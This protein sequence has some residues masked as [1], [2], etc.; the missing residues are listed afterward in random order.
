[1]SDKNKQPT[2]YVHDY[3]TFGQRP[4]L[5]RPAQFAGVRTDLDFNLVEEP[6][7]IYCKPADDYLPQPEAVMIT[8]I[9]PQ[10]ALANGVNEAEFS[11]QIHQAFSVP[12]TC[13]LGYNNIRFDDE[14]S[15]NIFYRNFYDPYAYSWQGGNSRWDLLDVMRA[16]YALRPEG[17]VWPENDDGLPSFK[18]EH[19]TKANGVEH[20]QAHDAMSDVY[21]TIAMAKLVKQAQPRLFDYLYQHRSKHKI[22]ALIDIAEMTPLVHVS[23]MFGAARGNTSWVAPLAWHPENKN[24]VIMCD[25]AGDMSPL[26]ELDSDTLRE[27][28]YTRRDKLQAQESAI[29]IK[30][31]HINKCPV[32]APAKTLLPENADRLGID[33]QRCLQNLQLLRQNP[34]VREKVV[35]LFAQAEPFA[36]TDDVD[37]Q[38]YNGFFSDA[39]RAT[40]KIIQQTEPQNLPALDLTFQDPRLEA[41]L[42]RFR[43]RNYPNTLNNSEQQRWLQHRRE[44]LSPERVQDYVLQLEQFYNQYEDDKEKL[45]LLKALFEY[46]KGLVS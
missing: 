6:L 36:V 23:G 12:G 5:D 1:M 39:D 33:R 25:L 2:F 11:R 43:A 4:A 22:N 42:F 21:A 24:A 17:I 40:M 38:L 32:L 18:L 13:I 19:L 15:R 3:E 7:V 14:V 10:H 45:A 30:L 16:C 8:G 37:T 28:L 31:V 41:L 44:A 46:A 9:T 20:L 29:P 27:R 35:A 34:Q 26:L